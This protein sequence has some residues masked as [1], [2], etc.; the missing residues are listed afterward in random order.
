MDKFSPQ[1]TCVCCRKKTDRSALVRLTEA[2]GIIIRDDRKTKPSRGVYVCRECF[3]D[4]GKRL[5]KAL[6]RAVKRLVTE[7]E[8]ESVKTDEDEF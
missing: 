4:G 6:S 8:S 7:E 3:S 1:R 2:D 5:A